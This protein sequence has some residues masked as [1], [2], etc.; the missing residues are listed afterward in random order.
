MAQ[1]DFDARASTWDDDPKKRARA[2]S[3]AAALRRRIDLSRRPRALEYGAGT[4]LLTF[5]IE[6]DLAEA[7][8]ADSSTG[9]LAVAD[10]KIAA[11]GLVHL[12]TLAI[13]LMTDPPPA[14][15]FDLIYSMMTLHHVPD[16]AAILRIFHDLLT[17]GGAIA[18]ADLDAEDGSF[19]GDNT[20]VLHRGF[21]RTGI[22]SYFEQ[23]GL[24]AVRDTTAAVVTKE[25]EGKGRREFPVFLVM[26][27]K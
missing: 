23:A 15:K 2:A 11:G 18:I 5:E 12:S 26:G 1:P 21:D 14:R 9:M 8:L 22:R 13:D 3:V 20:G 16:T 10:R 24:T 7:V 19:H 4:G 6:G 17:P 27:K 25:V